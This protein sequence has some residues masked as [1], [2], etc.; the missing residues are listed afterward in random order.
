MSQFIGAFLP[1]LASTLVG[2]VLGVP[3]ALYLN[4]RLMSEQNWNVS[5]ERV[6]RLD[7]AVKVLAGACQ[8]N[9]KVLENMAELAL[10]GKVLRNPDLRITTWDTVGAILTPTSL[11][12]DLL[13]TLSHHWLRL[14][15][16]ER[17][18]EEIFAREVGTLP[19]IEDQ[20]MMLGMWGEFYESAI[21][22][23]KHATEFNDRLQAL[24]LTSRDTRNPE[25][26]APDTRQRRYRK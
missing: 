4:N 1:N 6:R 5:V 8:Y 14:Q 19:Q 9:V 15:R 13:Q 7:D 25:G 20:E 11:D 2:I 26:S 3:I 18:N 22:L 24:N 10:A 16:L 17:L 23:A 21:N 12:P